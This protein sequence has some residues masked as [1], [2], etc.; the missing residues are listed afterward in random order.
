MQFSQYALTAA[1][2]AQVNKLPQDKRANRHDIQKWHAELV[3][4]ARCLPS[5]LG[6]GA[7]GHTA[8]VCRPGTTDYAT[9]TN[10]AVPYVTPIFPGPP[11]QLAGTV[12]A[13][14]NAKLI[15]ETNLQNFHIHEAAKAE[16]TTLIIATAGKYIESRRMPNVDYLNVTPDQFISTVYD[17]Y[18]TMTNQ[19]LDQNADRLKEPWNPDTQQFEELYNRLIQVQRVAQAADPIS[20][21]TLVRAG[22]TAIKNTHKFELDLRRWDALQDA[23]QTLAE[24]RTHFKAAFEAYLVS[25]QYGQSVTTL[26][27]GYNATTNL[28]HSSQDVNL[29]CSYCWSH[30]LYFNS[31]HN[32]KTCNKKLPGH[33]EEATLF[34]MMGGCNRII[35]KPGEKQIWRHP[36]WRPRNPNSQRNN[37]ENNPNMG[38]QE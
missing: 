12:A 23:Q 33:Q 26:Q 9:F 30:G 8:I 4:C 38:N 20:D 27:A 28:S 32:S 14:N 35:R 34:N 5:N 29:K 7:H 11:P 24:F 19:L 16:L 1:T 2:K 10:N 17:E 6:G 37:D 15:Y 25:P 13:I 36:L 21:R 22:V 31:T 18:G 3:Q